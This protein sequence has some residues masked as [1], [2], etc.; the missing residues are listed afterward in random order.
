MRD[1]IREKMWRR[2]ICCRV[3][4]FIWL[5]KRVLLSINGRISLGIVQENAIGIILDCRIIGILSLHKETKEQILIRLPTWLQQM[6]YPKTIIVDQHQG[7]KGSFNGEL[8]KNQSPSRPE[9]KY[10]ENFFYHMLQIQLY[11]FTW[12]RKYILDPIV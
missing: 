5:L 3:D 11:I 1:S 8:R 10:K 7:I 12:G 6:T 2:F 9:Y 4:S